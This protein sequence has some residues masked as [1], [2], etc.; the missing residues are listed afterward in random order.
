[1]WLG[2]RGKQLDGDHRKRKGGRKTIGERKRNENKREK[3]EGEEALVAG[4]ERRREE[5]E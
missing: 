2:D 3:G 4:A 1:M 5:R